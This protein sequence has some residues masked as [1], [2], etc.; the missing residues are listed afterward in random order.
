MVA[1]KTLKMKK[2]KEKKNEILNIHTSGFGKRSPGSMAIHT[3]VFDEA[4]VFFF[5]PSTSVGVGF[6]AARLST[7]D[8]RTGC[9][10]NRSGVELSEEVRDLFIWKEG[11]V[12]EGGRWGRA[13]GVSGAHELVGWGLTELVGTTSGFEYGPVWLVRPLFTCLRLLHPLF[14]YCKPFDF[15]VVSHFPHTYVMLSYLFLSLFP[16]MECWNVVVTRRRSRGIPVPF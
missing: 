3:D 4:V 9:F 16:S 1:E 14:C 8:C 2:K 5:G 12:G 6:V 10:G 7:H 11:K 13:K 15:L